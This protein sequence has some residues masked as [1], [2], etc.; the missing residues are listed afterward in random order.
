MNEKIRELMDEFT[1]LAELF[2]VIID[3]PDPFP[4]TADGPWKADKVRKRLSEIINE[5]DLAQRNEAM[6]SLYRKM[7]LEPWS[8]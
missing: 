6:N 8:G 7:E 2:V 1:Y 5:I 3:D 4:K